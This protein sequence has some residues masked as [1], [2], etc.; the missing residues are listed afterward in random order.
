VSLEGKNLR[1]AGQ[2]T[3]AGMPHAVIEAHGP[4]RIACTRDASGEV[5]VLPLQPG[6]ELDVRGHA[7][8]VAAQNVSYD[9]IQIEKLASVGHGGPGMYLDRFVAPDSEGLLLLHGYGNVF[10]RRL[11]DGETILVEPGGFL[12]K[13][14][15][16]AITPTP[17]QAATAL[18]QAN[19]AELTGP[20]RVGIQS[21][22]VHRRTS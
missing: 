16:V 14:A 7:F 11:G 8:L 22:Y 15:S 20:G 4:G 1:S 13:D 18:R 19:W 6:R 3:I 10:E 17:M 5:V 2:R 12:Y 21:M 9:F